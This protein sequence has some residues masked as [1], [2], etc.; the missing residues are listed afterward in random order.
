MR[1]RLDVFLMDGLDRQTWCILMNPQLCLKS[2]DNYPRLV[3]CQ[4]NLLLD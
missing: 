2:R 1:G 3:I 4:T